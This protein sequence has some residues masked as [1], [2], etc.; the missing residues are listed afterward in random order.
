MPTLIMKILKE[1]P[2]P[3]PSHFSKDL[4]S[5]INVMLTKSASFR[6]SV[7]DLLQLPFIKTHMQASI[8]NHQ[9]TLYY[10]IFYFYL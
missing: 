9:A 5:L 4:A 6:P 10:F 7:S 8:T 1:N 2:I 3:I